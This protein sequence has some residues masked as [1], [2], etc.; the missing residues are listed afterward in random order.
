LKFDNRMIFKK[1][2]MSNI[3]EAFDLYKTPGVVKGKIM[4]LNT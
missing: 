4:L 3:K 1:L 2:P